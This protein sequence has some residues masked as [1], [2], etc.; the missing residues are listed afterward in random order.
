MAFYILSFTADEFLSPSCQEI[1]SSFKLSE[2]LAGVTLL[3]FGGG[4]PDVF[5]SLSAA[6][7]GDMSGIE[8][9]ISVLLGGSL[10]II[11][12]INAGLIYYSP[13]TIEM[14]RTFFMRDA[15]FLFAGLV[16]LSYSIAIRGRIDMTMSIV[17][18][19]L[20]CVYVVAVLY[21]DR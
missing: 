20:Y 8:M 17:F 16:V 6:Q 14:N 19:A 9:G 1:S 4:A 15:F 7:G 10:F 21:Q 18:C 3:A 11:S 13:T 5:A 12:V 2:S